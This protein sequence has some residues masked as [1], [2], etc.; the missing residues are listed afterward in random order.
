M[1]RFQRSLLTSVV[2]GL[3]PVPLRAQ[4]DVGIQGGVALGDLVIKTDAGS[5]DVN[6]RAGVVAGLLLDY[7]VSPRVQLAIG[8]RLSQ[9]GGTLPQGAGVDALAR[10]SYAEVPFFVRLLPSAGGR[11]RPFVSAGGF[12]AFETN[13]DLRLEGEGQAVDIGCE[14][15]AARKKADHGLLFGAGAQVDLGSLD[16]VLG[17][18]YSLGLRNISHT[19]SATE[20][21]RTI[22]LTAG[23][24]YTLSGGR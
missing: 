9:K 23:L 12:L 4:I 13:C 24:S 21:T 16:L 14:E 20:K 22:A 5:E 10:L 15:A 8:G 17:A 1:T 3:L 6:R 19:T 7:R 18:D 2:I 11:V